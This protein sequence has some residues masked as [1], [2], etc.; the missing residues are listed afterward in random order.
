MTREQQQGSPLANRRQLRLDRRWI[1]GAGL[2]SAQSEHHGTV[3]SVPGAGQRQR[4]VKLSPKGG[5][6][7]ATHR[8]RAPPQIGGT[9]VS[10]TSYSFASITNASDS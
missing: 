4:S 1:N 5:H 6:P 7:R 2:F 9:L 3:G 8:P 10:T